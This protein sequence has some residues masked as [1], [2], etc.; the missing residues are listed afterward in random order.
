MTP[1]L[2]SLSPSP[3]CAAECPVQL[4]FAVR[5]ESC[6]WR[7]EHWSRGRVIQLAA[8]VVLSSVQVAQQSAA[9]GL[10]RLCFQLPP[11]PPVS[12]W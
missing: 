11:E 10:P 12:P 6:H 7:S 8:V 4:R 9:R 5:T 2:W 3:G 1:S